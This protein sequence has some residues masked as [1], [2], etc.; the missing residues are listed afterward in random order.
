VRIFEADSSSR[1]FAKRAKAWILVIW[2]YARIN[3]T[4]D[5]EFEG[6]SSSVK[7]QKCLVLPIPPPVMED[8]VEMA[9]ELVV[10]KEAA[11]EVL[12]LPFQGKQQRLELART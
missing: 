1:D 8:A 9:G 2:R 4:R 11:A 3:K 10:V 6:F 12:M 5:S 7:Q